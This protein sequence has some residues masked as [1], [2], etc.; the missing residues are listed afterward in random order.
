MS[1]DV[2]ERMLA[3]GDP[4]LVYV[5]LPLAA[6]VATRELVQGRTAILP[7]AIL[8]VVAGLALYALRRAS[9]HLRAWVILMYGVGLGTLALVAFGPL[10]GVGVIYTWTI[11]AAA[12]L[13][14]RNAMIVTLSLSLVSMAAV[15][16]GNV[17][18][19]LP[20]LP[21]RAFDFARAEPWL[22]FAATLGTAGAAIGLL[23]NRII[24]T[25]ETA[26]TEATQALERER[27]ERSERARP[28]RP[29]RGRSGSRPSGASR[30]AW[31]TISTTR[32][33]SSC[34]TPSRCARRRTITVASSPT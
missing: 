6:V 18:G 17:K 13:I 2:R 25:L 27:V 4:F 10:L 16:V 28:G 24:W 23:T 1:R 14:G 15:A 20:P 19:W 21:A 30:R 9:S 22:R 7:Y 26:L 31:P 34:A 29:S 33:R 5:A 32:S 11:V 3:I 8:Q 12:G